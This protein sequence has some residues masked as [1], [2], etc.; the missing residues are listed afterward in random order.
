MTLFIV[1]G[2]T[3]TSGAI[4]YGLYCLYLGDSRTS[5][6]MMRY[7]VGFQFFTICAFLGGFGLANGGANLNPFGGPKGT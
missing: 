1:A 7:R 2:V 4:I 6:L 3:A 5:Q